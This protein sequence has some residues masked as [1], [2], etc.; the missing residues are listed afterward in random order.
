MRRLEIEHPLVIG[1]HVL[2]ERPL[3]VQ[4][5]LSDHAP[6]LAELQHESLLG[7]PDDEEGAGQ[8]DAGRDQH[9]ADDDKQAGV[10]RRR[11]ALDADPET[12]GIGDPGPELAG[13]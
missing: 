1:D 9:D 5:G 4:P 13:A 3:H 7:L 8:Q 6:H 11:P 2:D 12:G 10:H